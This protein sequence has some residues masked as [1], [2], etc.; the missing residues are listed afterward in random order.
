MSQH[1]KNGIFPMSFRSVLITVLLLCGVSAARAQDLADLLDKVRPS[2]V[3]VETRSSEGKGLGTG[4]LIQKDGLILTAA[5]VVKGARTIQVRFAVGNEV[6]DAKVLETDPDADFAVI[7]ISGDN[8][9]ALPLGDSDHLRQGERV[10]AIGNPLG[11]DFTASEGIVSALRDSDGKALSTSKNVALI[12]TTAAISQGNSGGPIFN[13]QGE[14]VGI[15][16]FKMKNGENL[17]FALAIN[18]VKPTVTRVTASG[19]TPKRNTPTAGDNSTSNPD[20]NFF[21]AAGGAARKPS[22][23]TAKTGN[24]FL[25]ASRAQ[26][27]QQVYRFVSEQDPLDDKDTEKWVK[28]K[29]DAGY[30]ITDIAG[31]TDRWVIMM[32]KNSSY[33]NRSLITNP[34]FPVKRV[35]ELWNEDAYI[36]SVLYGFDRWVVVMSRYPKDVAANMDQ[37]MK[38]SADYPTAW[39]DGKAAD[40]YRVT[41]VNSDGKVWLVVMT[42][43][44]G[45]GQQI[46]QIFGENGFPKTWVEDNWTKGYY[47]TSYGTGPKGKSIVVMSQGA[48]YKQQSYWMGAA[49]PTNWVKEKWGDGWDITGVR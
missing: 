47:I 11:L 8:Y 45:L 19:Y 41:S 46:S 44:T 37:T 36:T 13:Y 10:I 29:W 5:H 17:N 33:E 18:R 32:T 27:R 26:D 21:K 1:R 3:T 15:A 34:D 2:V 23:P 20:A 35:Q 25:I 40:G 38:L 12:Q 30:Q 9:P 42:K 39:I 49:F 31:G 16:V 4:F 6:R 43:G 14:V 22:P 28:E 7:K 24:W 48:K